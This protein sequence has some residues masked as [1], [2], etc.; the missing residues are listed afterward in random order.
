[1]DSLSYK[2]KEALEIFDTLPASSDVYSNEGEYLEQWDSEEV[3]RF[4]VHYLKLFT[5]KYYSFQHLGSKLVYQYWPSIKQLP[6]GA[7]KKLQGPWSI[8]VHTE[9]GTIDL[10]WTGSRDEEWEEY[11]CVLEDLEEGTKSVPKLTFE[12]L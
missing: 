9:E 5:D 10:V 1:M 4:A 12:M 11:A 7:E 2:Q 6:Y 8:N 3:A